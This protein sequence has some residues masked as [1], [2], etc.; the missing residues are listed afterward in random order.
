LGDAN[1]ANSEC[2]VEFAGPCQLNT[3]RQVYGAGLSKAVVRFLS[4]YVHQNRVEDVSAVSQLTGNY[5]AP[6]PAVEWSKESE[7][8]NHSNIVNGVVT[9]LVVKNGEEPSVAPPCHGWFN[10]QQPAQTVIINGPERI[11]NFVDGTPG[12]QIIV[13]VEGDNPVRFV[14]SDCK[15]WLKR[16]RDKV[17][18]RGST[19]GLVL[20]NNNVWY[21]FGNM[22]KP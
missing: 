18:I 22:R 5:R 11:V 13:I 9:P 6:V 3:V 10:G 12:Q 15:M 21:E 17:L 14:H 2:L 4:D 7:Y 20:G 16:E 19:F 8:G 1:Q